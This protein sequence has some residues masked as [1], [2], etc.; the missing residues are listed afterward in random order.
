VVIRPASWYDARMLRLHH[1]NLSIPVDG[2]D[3]EA[4]FLVDYLNYEPVELTPGTPRG[5]KWFAGEDGAQIHLSEDPEHHPSK[6][7]HVAIELGDSLNDLK[8]KFDTSDYEYT[9]Y[10][11]PD[12]PV[13]F[14]QDPAGNRWELRGKLVD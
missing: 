6:R 4:A 8:S 2:A 7:A 9:T 1:V 3:A 10:H 11:G 12:G 14:C 13:L 5:A